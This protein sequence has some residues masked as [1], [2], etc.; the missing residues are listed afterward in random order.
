M[1]LWQRGERQRE[2]TMRHMPKEEAEKIRWQGCTKK[3]TREHSEST[4]RTSAKAVHASKFVILIIKHLKLHLDLIYMKIH[5]H[6]DWL[7]A[8]MTFGE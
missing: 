3:S 2:Q 4:Y 7:M 8:T 1:V 5:S 6:Y